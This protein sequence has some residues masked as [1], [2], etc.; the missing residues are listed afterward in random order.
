MGFFTEDIAIDL[1]T[2]NTLI[3]HN[4]EVVI[5][6]PSMV[7]LDRTTK[8]IIAI[9][10]SG[11]DY[12]YQNSDKLIQKKKFI[13]HIETAIELN[14]PII[15]HSREAEIDTFNILKDFSCVYQTP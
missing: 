5:D 9:G 14:L 15:N 12:Y 4:D 11:L 8:K 10:E 6:S 1:G 13:E 2:A 3:I 7:A